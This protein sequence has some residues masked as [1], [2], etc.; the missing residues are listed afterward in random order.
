[1]SQWFLIT[2]LIIFLASATAIVVRI[3][4]RREIKRIERGDL[5]ADD[6]DIIE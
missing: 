1:M 4:S 5:S 6:F 2:L 3:Q